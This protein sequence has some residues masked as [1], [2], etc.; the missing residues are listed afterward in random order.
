MNK[1][2]VVTQNLGLSEDQGIRLSKIGDVKFYKDLPKDESEWLCR[3]QEAD[4]ILSG[5]HW[6]KKAMLKLE[7]KFFSF[8]FV[9]YGWLDIE[10]CK[11]KNIIVAISPGCN[12]DAVAEWMVGF[13]I[14]LLRQQYLFINMAKEGSYAGEAAKT[15]GLRDKKV[16]VLGKGHVGSKVGKICEAFD[17]VVEYFVRGDDLF[18][19][20]QYADVVF[21]CLS[22][23]PT[24]EKLLDDNFFI[25]LKEG[26]YFI[27]ATSDE[28]FDTDGLMHAL[29][30]GHL[31][32]AGID[33]GSVSVGDCTN[34]YYLKLARHGKILATP[35]VAYNTDIT[36]LICGD[37]M[38]E[39]VEAWVNGQPI[40]LVTR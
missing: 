17:M 10:K 7:N 31:A 14:N 26:A 11:E 12:K 20:T 36:N 34:L 21:N 22:H 15:I 38:I 6:A 32:G 19:K 29:D 25:N 39:N 8:P 24:T 1:K 33:A 16:S 2:I 4:I 13:M 3:C 23:N 18:K 9:G 5:K 40:N 37:M 35:H 28:V 30:S 27:S